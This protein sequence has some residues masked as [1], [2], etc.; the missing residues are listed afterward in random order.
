VW[1]EV[2]V[3]VAVTDDP[4]QFVKVVFGHER[5]AKNDSETEVLKTESQIHATNSKVVERR[6]EELRRLVHQGMDEAPQPRD[7]ARREPGARP[8]RRRAP[9]GYS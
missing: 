8:R 5:I 9:S 7:P 1:G 3:T 6:V 4:P 2:S